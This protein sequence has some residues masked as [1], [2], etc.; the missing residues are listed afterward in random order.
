MS[1]GRVAW[2]IS[3]TVLVLVANVAASVLY[4]VVYSYVIDPGHEPQY[5]EDH[6]Q[7]A[8]PY[9]SIAMGIPLMFLAGW[10]VSGWWGRTLGVKGAL[11]V[12]LAYVVI[13]L[14]ILMLAGISAWIAVLFIVSFA[15]KLVAAYSGARVGLGLQASKA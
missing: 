10:R 11:C 14:L 4:M 9:C 5:Y 15:T 1:G 8:A 7:I 6:I 2:L 12:W 13:D 3:V